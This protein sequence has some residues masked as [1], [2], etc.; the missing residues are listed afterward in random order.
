MVTASKNWIS[1]KF[2]TETLPKL[3][4]IEVFKFPA[5]LATLVERAA[6]AALASKRLKGEWFA[7]SPAEAMQAVRDVAAK[8]E[9]D[10]QEKQKKS[11]T[12]KTAP[13]TLVSIPTFVVEGS[14]VSRISIDEYFER[15]DQIQ[16]EKDAPKRALVARLAAGKK[17]KAEERASAARLQSWLNS[18]RSA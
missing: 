4:L 17:R 9:A 5:G 2:Q 1:G 14:V 10:W 16:K 11:A 13:V 18:Q 12:K 6:H 8:S 3:H 15:S 7:V